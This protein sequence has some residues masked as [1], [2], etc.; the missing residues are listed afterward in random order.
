MILLLLVTYIT[1]EGD[2]LRRHQDPRKADDE[3]RPKWC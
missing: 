1:H 2:R 3:G